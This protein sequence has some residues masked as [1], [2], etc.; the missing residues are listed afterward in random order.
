MWS[1]KEKDM[2]NYRS[3]TMKKA[4][5]AAGYREKYAMDN[6]TMSRKTLNGHTVLVYRYS[7]YDP[8][9]DANGA[10]FDTV[11]NSWVD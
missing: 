8:Y 1:E 5:E 11:S 10:T 2:K 3:E 4:Y 6:G 7:K 9:Q